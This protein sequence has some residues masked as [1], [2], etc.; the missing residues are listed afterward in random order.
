M[1]L[2]KIATIR[3]G[4]D[5]AIHGHT[6]FR[7]NARGL[8]SVY[9]LSSLAE[10][11]EPI[12]LAGFTLGSSEI[13]TPHSNSVCFGPDYYAEGDEFPLL[14]SNVYN[15]YAGK[16][17]KRIGECCVYRIRR[18]GA[19]FRADLVQ[20]IAIGFCEDASLWKASPEGHGVRPYGNFLVDPDTRAYYAYVMRNEEL[21]TRYFRFD[22]PSVHA[23]DPDPL[24]GVPRFV[25]GVEDIRESFDLPFYRYIQ[26]GIINGGRLYST[27]GFE[28]DEKNP[29]AIRVVDL[30]G[31]REEYHY[32]PALGVHEEPEMIDF[33]DGACYYSDGN[34]NFY[35]VSF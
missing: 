5:G 7:L 16:P 31:H 20:L 10:G 19:G 8:C 33:M 11:G 28:R 6:L 17:D 29:P 18:E 27:E 2:K 32:L 22:L 1:K 4:Q 12:L 14:Y 3:S 35:T 24:L 9:D 15:N 23:G 30:A 34:G 25:L 13:L 26:G 21:G